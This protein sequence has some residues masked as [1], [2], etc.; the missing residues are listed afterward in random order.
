[1][2]VTDDTTANA[3]SDAT[4]PLVASEHS[5]QDPG[6]IRL[7]PGASIA[8]GRF[9]LLVFHGGPKHLQFWQALDTASGRQVALTVV[10]PD[11]VLPVRDVEDIL[12]RTGGL[13]G[14]DMPGIA[15]VLGVVRIGGVGLVVSEWIRG[16]TLREVADTAPSPIRVADALQSLVGAAEAA[17]RAGIALSIDH[18]NR[19]RVSTN[20]DV[21]LAFPATMP[22]ASPQDDLRGIGAALYALLVNRWPFREQGVPH[23][24]AR[25]EL[26]PE[27]RPEEPAALNPEIPFL[28]SAA[29]AGLVREGGGIRSSA[30]TLALL[31]Q[32]TDE[33]VEGQLNSSVGK[34]LPLPPPGS[35]AGFRN[36]GPAERAEAAHRQTTR[37]CLG[38]CAAVLVVVV[39]MLAST[40]SRILGNGDAGAALNADKLGLRPASAAPAA[41][42]HA[43]PPATIGDNP[44]KPVQ[45]SVFSPGG[46]PDSPDSAGS[47]I[48]GDPATAWSTDAYFDAAPFPKFK[49]GVGLLLQLPQPMALSAVTVDLHST[50]TMVQVRSSSSPT[51]SRLA[52]TTELTP[53]TPM[54]PGQNS[55]S[56][57]NPAPV[58]NVLVWITT[59][60]TTGGKSQS[61]IS[62][63]TLQPAPPRA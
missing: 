46:A 14:I 49:E 4:S 54:Q 38:A 25:A 34:A 57:N 23:E 44:A 18:P 6:D 1:M 63:I 16:A 27:G 22:A 35:Y 60:G 8:D 20:G 61:D 52:D 48:D 50:G 10:D 55:I 53:P 62:E 41:P 40:F 43:Q 31:R 9:R 51:P 28:I 12:W 13:R 3:T 37:A 36:F 11:G 33:A 7:V 59:L 39:M 2:A 17:H 58:S 45:A 47:A 56:V 29:A 24:W 42:P 32:A 5:L 26:D 19:V 30:T 21:V 15:T